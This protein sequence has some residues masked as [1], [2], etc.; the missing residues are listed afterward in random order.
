M[1][2]PTKKR[3]MDPTVLSE[4][5]EEVEETVESIPLKIF[6]LTNDGD[7]LLSEEQR[8]AQYTAQKWKEIEHY[9]KT[10]QE[11]RAKLEVAVTDLETVSS[12]ARVAHDPNGWCCNLE[13]PLDMENIDKEAKDTIMET[14]W[15]LLR[16]E[17]S[18]PT[19]FQEALW[20]HEEGVAEDEDSLN[21]ILWR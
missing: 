9:R 6:H 15:I 18:L 14:A 12:L 20:S 21:A 5:E 19:E 3:K 7:T 10:I 13:Y 4:E 11:Y 17:G 1:E 8:L 2:S 16:S